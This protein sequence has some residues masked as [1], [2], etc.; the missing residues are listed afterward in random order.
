VHQP[1]STEEPAAGR[2]V[3]VTIATPLQPALVARIAEVDDRLD[4]RY[5]PELLPPPRYPCDHRGSD[6]FRRSPSEEKRW[7]NLLAEAEVMFGIPGDSTQGL[8]EV[9]R[10]NPTLRWIQGTAAGVGETVRQAQLS[11]NERARVAITSAAGVHAGPLA[12]FALLGLLALT[13]GL[14]RLLADAEA[15]RWEHY[16][17]A[18]LSG[19]TLLVVGLGAIGREVARLG[20]AL[21]MRVIAINRTGKAEGAAV[22]EIHPTSALLDLLSRAQAVVVTLPLTNETE[23][24]ID[25]TAI[26][27]MPVGAV[28]VNVGRGGVIDEPALV[29]ALQE[30]RVGGA[31]LDVF[32]TEPLP[33]DSP[34][35]WLPNVLISPH[36]AALSVRENAR[37]VALF[38]ENLRRY[39]RGDDLLN[40]VN[41]I[42]Y[43]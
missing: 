5:E 34:L 23:N 28:V 22:D 38:S 29:Q 17:V 21:G 2:Q 9:V 19:R 20:T 14:P 10:A 43:Y 40:R 27:R 25:A 8:A 24:L 3:L 16:P 7:A 15:R 30:G 11:E 35:W 13:K 18:E 37:I 6:T 42:L 33:L 36:T 31:A 26:G 41:P 39:L 1:L 12:E 32:A 4:L